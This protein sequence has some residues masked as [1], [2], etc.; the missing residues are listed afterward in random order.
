MMPR[1]I[2]DEGRDMQEQSSPE[3]AL[4]FEA[5]WCALKED[6]AVRTVPT[7]RY[8][9]VHNAVHAFLRVCARREMS[10]VASA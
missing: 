10:I 1:W 5:P 7:L 6:L 4:Q 3:R 2:Y 9:A 8:I